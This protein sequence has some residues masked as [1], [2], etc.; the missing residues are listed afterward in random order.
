MLYLKMI[1][2]S[3]QF[4]VKNILKIFK[5]LIVVGVSIVAL[6]VI[7]TVVFVN[8]APQLGAASKGL[9][10]KRIEASENYH[11]GKFQNQLPTPVM[12]GSGSFKAT[13]DYLKGGE[14]LIPKGKIP[15]YP[16]DPQSNNQYGDS[17]PRITWFG[18]SAVLIEI[19]TYTL[20]ADPMLGQRASPVSFAGSKRFTDEMPVAI[21]DLPHL[22]A[23]LISHDHYDHLD[24]GTIVQLKDRTD[25]F[26]VPL[27]VGAHLERWDV[28]STKI[29][30]LD[31]WDHADYKG[32]SLAATPARHFSGRSLMDETK[33][34]GAPG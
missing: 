9:R 33:L 31:W 21:A 4:H 22:D 5:K 6:L 15:V 25:H 24:Y 32:I 8:V 29:T 17:L 26:F 2:R 10:L 14:G 30:E 20:F 16:F 19:G 12:V 3:T 11:D 7:G 18:H 27:G 13:L 1:S 28:D 34:Y 23:V